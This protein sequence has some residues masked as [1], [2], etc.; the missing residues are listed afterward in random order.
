MSKTGLVLLFAVAIFLPHATNAQSSPINV[1]NDLLTGSMQQLNGIALLGSSQMAFTSLTKLI[2]SILQAMA[3]MSVPYYQTQLN[4]LSTQQ[5][6]LL[7]RLLTLQEKIKMN[8]LTVQATLKSVGASLRSH[9]NQADNAVLSYENSIN[10]GIVT[11]RS[12]LDNLI[13]AT[14]TQSD[15]AQKLLDDQ[16]SLSNDVIIA[17]NLVAAQA[18]EVGALQTAPLTEYA[19]V[20]LP[21][22]SAL[23]LISPN[24]VQLPINFVNTYTTQPN[25]SLFSSTL[26]PIVAADRALDLVLISISNTGMILNVCSRA[27]TYTYVATQ[28]SYYIV[29]NG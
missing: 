1:L 15:A 13:N 14:P 3:Q 7:N 27:P 19:N 12:L 20:L 21:D 29:S 18:T 24:C 6:A 26:G 10:Y 25:V 5:Q 23:D 28:V 22:P 4:A 8:Q 9:T 16:L 17:T 11:I 2:D